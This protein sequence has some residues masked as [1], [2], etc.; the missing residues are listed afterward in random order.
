MSSVKKGVIT[1]SGEWARHLRPYG[2]RVYWK[3]ER[4]AAKADARAR[5]D[6]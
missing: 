5:I 4:K 1:A 2:R 3:C 6:D